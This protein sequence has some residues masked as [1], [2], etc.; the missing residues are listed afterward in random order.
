[1]TSRRRL[2]ALED[3]AAISL[4]TLPPGEAGVLLARLAARPG[5][6]AGDPAVGEITRLCGCLPLALGML[7][8]RLH[9][10]PA[11]TAAGLAADLAGARDRLELMQAEN[12]SVAAASNSA[13]SSAAASARACSRSRSCSW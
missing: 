11:W 7:A 10:H 6:R 9:H 3:A 13:G 5:V 4:D 1:M 2:T 12:V 8:R